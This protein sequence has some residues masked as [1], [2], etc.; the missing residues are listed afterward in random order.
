MPHRV[1]VALE[2]ANLLHL[3]V[4]KIHFELLNQ[5]IFWADKENTVVSSHARTA[6]SDVRPHIALNCLMF[7][8]VHII[9]QTYDGGVSFKVGHQN[10]LVVG[11]EVARE[12]NS[13]GLVIHCNRGWSFSHV[14]ICQQTITTACR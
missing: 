6:E 8:N 13:L 12:D 14:P 11:E 3:H 7:N 4:F 10:V 2:E 5:F 1:R 9:L